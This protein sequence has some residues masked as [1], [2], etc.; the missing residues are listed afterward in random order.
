MVSTFVQCRAAVEDGAGPYVFDENSE[1]VELVEESLQQEDTLAVHAGTG[2]ARGAP[3][4]GGRVVQRAIAG[5]LKLRAAPAVLGR[6]LPRILGAAAVD[7]VFVPA[8]SLPEFGLLIDRVA[9]VFEY[10]R[11]YVSRAMLRATGAGCLELLIDVTA[12]E[13]TLLEG[14]SFPSLTVADDLEEQPYRLSDVALTLVAAPRDCSGFELVVDNGLNVRRV[15]SVAPVSIA[16]GRRSISL[17]TVHPYDA[18]H[19]SLS[20]STS[21]GAGQ[22]RLTHP[23]GTTTFSFPQLQTPAADPGVRVRR[24][25]AS[26]AGEFVLELNARAVAN[27]GAAEVQVSHLADAD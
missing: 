8:Q 2:S 21:S 18:T 23:A 5:Q 12:M 14:D 1:V 6:W 25:D 19:A 16:P 17:K 3:D 9:G 20:E 7:D 22:L 27:G 24:V 4:I 15:H 13:R 11:C 26:G 10:Q